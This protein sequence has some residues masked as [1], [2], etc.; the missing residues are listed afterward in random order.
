MHYYNTFPATYH[1]RLE[2]ESANTLGSAL[3]TCLEFEEQLARIGL[4]VED[5]V[6]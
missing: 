5:F 4:P 3:Q 1:H 6:K 2:E